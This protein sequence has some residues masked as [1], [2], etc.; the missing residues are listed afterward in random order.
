M[1][2]YESRRNNET[3]SSGK[4]ETI[5]PR[6]F[7][8]EIHDL[9]YRKITIAEIED[10]AARL[11]E[12]AYP[13]EIVKRLK[14]YEEKIAEIVLAGF[15]DEE[16]SFDMFPIATAYDYKGPL[17]TTV[18][19]TI[20]DKGNPSSASIMVNQLTMPEVG[21]SLEE[22]AY[23]LRDMPPVQDRQGRVFCLALLETTNVS[24]VAINNIPCGM[25]EPGDLYKSLV[26]IR[27][28]Q[29]VNK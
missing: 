9:F 24:E 10:A 19:D 6:E 11:G 13:V 27:Q 17:S 20:I 15:G 28:P 1:E 18:L 16:A 21:I 12:E 22:K 25:M 3:S 8:E 4:E 7:K 26:F 5:A 2:K 29:M 23:L 14:Y